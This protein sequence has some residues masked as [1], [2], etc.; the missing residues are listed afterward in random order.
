MLVWANGL[1]FCFL[2]IT[3][4]T[5]EDCASAAL[6]RHSLAY[7]GALF[8]L[9]PWIPFRAVTVAV[10]L[11]G[12]S[13]GFDPTWDF[14][15]AAVD[16]AEESSDDSDNQLDGS[17]KNVGEGLQSLPEHHE[18][19]ES[20]P[21]EEPNPDA[22]YLDAVSQQ[23]EPDDWPDDVPGYNHNPF[24]GV[25]RPGWFLEEG[26]DVQSEDPKIRQ[27][28]QKLWQ[29]C[30][31]GDAALAAELL[32][33]GAEVNAGDPANEWQW[34]ALMHCCA[35]PP[36]ASVPDAV[37]ADTAKEVERKR[38]D[39]VQCLLEHGARVQVT[40]IYGET[41]IH[42]AA[43]RGYPRLVEQLIEAGVDPFRE[44]QFGCSA[45]RIAELNQKHNPGCAAAADVIADAGGY[46]AGWPGAPPPPLL[47]RPSADR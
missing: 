9:P 42:Y 24:V 34:T 36:A 2:A 6:T 35:P 46:D 14:A 23:L 41:P 31:D 20:G 4:P 21:E 26:V 40:D 44:N 5:V 38:M 10:N 45:Q 39:L 1:V 19:P 30:D 17:L 32:S 18:P 28:N 27:L 29:A 7:R 33:Q 25:K 15:G 22:A 8:S 47:P 43:V 12:G 37:T 16:Q 11:R 13:D 3:I